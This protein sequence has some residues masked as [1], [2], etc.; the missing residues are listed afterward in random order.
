MA[1]NKVKDVEIQTAIIEEEK[2][3]SKV[4]V[5]FVILL[6]VVIWLAI[7]IFCIRRDVGGF[8]SSV[9]QPVLKDVPVLHHIL[10]DTQE[11]K[12]IEDDNYP[13][14]TLSEAIQRIKE[15]ELELLDAQKVTSADDAKVQELQA[16]VSRLKQFEDKQTAFQREKEEFY[17]KIIYT[18]NAPEINEYKKYYESIEPAN[19]ELLYKQVVKET[20]YKD[21]VEEYASAYGEM[22]P[23]Q[24]AKI[25]EAMTDKLELAAEILEAIDAEPRGKIL[26][27]MNPEIAAKL[28]KIMQPEE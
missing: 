18:D 25:I 7:L 5:F 12:L 19:A 24:A 1:K 10:P 9:L 28:T 13:Y 21:Q 2:A 3:G 17:E 8:G 11:D 20:T 22:K 15:L 14:T 26:G 27:A 16:E 23:A 6:F 4:S